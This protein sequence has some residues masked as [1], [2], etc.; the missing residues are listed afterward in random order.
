MVYFPLL[1]KLTVENYGLYPGRDRTGRFEIDFDRGLTLVLG[2]NGLGKS[3]LMLLLFRLIAGTYDIALPEGEVG[4]SDL[5]AHELNA[6]N[7]KQ[8]A[9]RVHD[10]A[11]DASAHL[12]FSLGGRSFE[13]VRSLS[14]LDLIRFSIDDQQMEADEEIYQT[15][16]VAAAGLGTYADWVLVL[17][18]LVFFFE[19]RRALVWDASA[20]RQLL[21]ALLLSPEQA[22]EWTTQER[23]ILELDSRMR[24]L[25]AV[26]KREQRERAKK[27]EQIENLP[28][29]RAALVAAETRLIQLNDQHGKLVH[30]IG[31]AD[32]SRH[33]ARLNA[34]RAQAA[35]DQALRELDR[36]RIVAVDALLPEVD[37]SMRF[38]LA[39]LLSDQQCLVC[40]TSGVVSKREKLLAAIDSHH[41]VICDSELSAPDP[42]LVYVGDDHL[43]AL[44]SRVGSLAT[45]AQASARLRDEAIR[46]YETNNDELVRCVAE[47]D[48][49]NDQVQALMLQLPADEHRVT[50]QQKKLDI[51]EE[52]ITDLRAQLKAERITFADSLEAYRLT[53]HQFAE[54]IKLSFNEAARG[55]LFEEAGLSWAP[56]KRNVG[57]AGTEGIEPVEYPAFAVELSGSDFT[58]M[59]RR[60]RPGEVSESQR[61]F[62]DLAF[63]MALIE[64]AS[65]EQISTLAIDA[66]ESSLD[67]VF[68]DRAASVLARFANREAGLGNRL[69]ITSN[70]GA[71]QLVPQLLR[72]ATPAGHRTERIV[73][74]FHAGVPTRAMVNSHD[75]Y[76]KYWDELHASIESDDVG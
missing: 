25:Q 42:S 30:L 40:G 55:F 15:A 63:R 34:M 41:C 32:E 45:E 24:N 33:A 75:A 11:N 10:A 67:A 20:Q 44:Q 62:I 52:M 76:E 69:I 60:N 53:I 26:L 2:A 74:L 56:V 31:A 49:T 8:F 22:K 7:K 57:Q 18:T 70:L 46:D 14:N 64:V 5:D 19:D 72:E 43:Q 59:Q 71:G 65:P 16:V 28:G 54:K 47:R 73:D 48:D 50:D 51:V 4:S 1:R 21:R 61:E 39:R 6:R 29:V 68:V 66:P 9:V 23:A 12:I 38:I 27:I 58:N 17:R 36:A 13:V 35:H 37:K 3:T